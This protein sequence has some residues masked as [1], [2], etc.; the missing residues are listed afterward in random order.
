MTTKVRILHR[1]HEVVL[2]IGD[3]SVTMSELELSDVV[4]QGR[5]ILEEARRP[6]K[7]KS[8]VRANCRPPFVLQPR[9]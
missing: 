8:G 4:N 5:L 3:Q 6:V 7:I 1:G 9:D 2:C